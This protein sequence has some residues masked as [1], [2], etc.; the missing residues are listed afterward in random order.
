MLG[1]Y[2]NTMSHNLHFMCF[3]IAIWIII[4]GYCSD[5]AADAIKTKSGGL[6]RIVTNIKIR[7]D[8]IIK[9]VTMRVNDE[10]FTDDL[11]ERQL[12]REQ[13]GDFEIRISSDGSNQIEEI[14]VHP[15]PRISNVVFPKCQTINLI[16]CGIRSL[17]NIT[18]N[19]KHV[20]L[21][22][23][24]LDYLRGLVFNVIAD[25]LIIDMSDCWINNQELARFQKQIKIVGNDDNDKLVTWILNQNR[26]SSLESF[27]PPHGINRVFLDFNPIRT[28]QK[29]AR[30]KSW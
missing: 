7:G 26:I 22:R 5:N 23:N 27:V 21:A 3:L 6:S 19:S 29:R 25:E 20:K 28:K 17:K 11:G 9:N 16:G 24:A 30:R 1:P 15:A 8:V 13:L 2:F 18:F 14:T 12:T 10:L 4:C